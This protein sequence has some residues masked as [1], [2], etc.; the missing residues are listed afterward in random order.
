MSTTSSRYCCFYTHTH[1]HTQTARARGDP[2]YTTIDGLT[3][4]FTG[5]G[6]YTVIEIANNNSNSPMFS[7]QGR[8]GPGGWPATV[9]KA[10]AVGIPG[11]IGFQVIYGGLRFVCL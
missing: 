1:T 2:H 5:A 9:V 8:L 4:T 3:Y 6:E 11:Q 10:L 7:L